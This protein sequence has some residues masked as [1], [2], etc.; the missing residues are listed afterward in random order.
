MLSQLKLGLLTTG[1]L[2]LCGCGGGVADAPDMF[3]V[4]GTVTYDGQPLESGQ[5]LFINADGSGR[6]DAGQITNG[7]FSF[8]CAAGEKKVEITS[9]REVPAEAP[10]GLPDYVSLIPKEYN[11]ESMLKAS[12]KAGGSA[13]DH[14]FKFET[15]SK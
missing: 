5:I 3:E 12:V 9:T 4:K 14:T 2:V 13:E 15:T 10:D 11:T 1:I 8:K 7:E 6:P